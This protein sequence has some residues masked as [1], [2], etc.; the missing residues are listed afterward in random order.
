MAVL[1]SGNCAGGAARCG[2]CTRCWKTTKFDSLSRWRQKSRG[3]TGS[4]SVLRRGH[5]VSGSVEESATET[6]AVEAHVHLHT[7]QEAR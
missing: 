1:S 6:V 5:A 7:S 4:V 2:R 3:G